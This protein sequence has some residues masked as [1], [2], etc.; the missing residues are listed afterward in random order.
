MGLIE[1]M[2]LDPPLFFWGT[3]LGWKKV[4]RFVAIENMFFEPPL[5]FWG[6]GLEIWGWMFK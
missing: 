1:K 3:G 4:W 6:T 2:F 5:I